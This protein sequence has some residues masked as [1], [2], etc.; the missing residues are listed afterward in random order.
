MPD[1]LVLLQ[2]IAVAILSPVAL[3]FVI[4][5]LWIILVITGLSL[6]YGVLGIAMLIDWAF[7]KRKRIVPEGWRKR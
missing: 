7:P 3:A 5:T 2:W 4:C 1:P 6:F